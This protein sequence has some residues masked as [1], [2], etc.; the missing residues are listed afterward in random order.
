[1]L[2]EVITPFFGTGGCTDSKEVD[3]Q[4]AVEGSLQ[5]MVMA[6]VGGGMVHD[7]HCWLDHGS[8]LSPAHMVLGQEILRNNFV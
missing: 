7:T 6:T 3:V 2:Y 4:A 8:T 5:D 1:M